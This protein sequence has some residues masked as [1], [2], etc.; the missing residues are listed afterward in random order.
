[1]GQICAL[2]MH[3]EAAVPS[4]VWSNTECPFHYVSACMRMIHVQLKCRMPVFFVMRRIE[5]KKRKINI[6]H[7]QNQIWAPQ[8]VGISSGLLKKVFP[9]LCVCLWLAT[10]YY[11]LRSLDPF[12]L[13]KSIIGKGILER[14]W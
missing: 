3:P 12:I 1:M 4:S 10:L 8:V 6:C 7:S 5:R 11:T 13:L 9:W 2:L 14:D